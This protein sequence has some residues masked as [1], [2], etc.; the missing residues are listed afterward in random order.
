MRTTGDQAFSVYIPKL[1]VN[2]SVWNRLQLYAGAGS[3][4]MSTLLA[5]GRRGEVGAKPFFFK[6]FQVYLTKGTEGL[7]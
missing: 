7:K 2:N 3:T 5:W 1:W 4:Y 6:I